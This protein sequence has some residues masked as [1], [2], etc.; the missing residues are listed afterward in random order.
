[1]R[2]LLAAAVTLLVMTNTKALSQSYGLWYDR[3]AMTWTQALPI[4]NGRLG[5]MVY[6]N[7]GVEHIQLNEETIWA[8]QPNH[9]FNPKAKA[10]LP[11]V[12]RLIFDGKYREAQELINSDIMPGYDRSNGMPYQTFGD[13]Y[14]SMPGHS[15]YTDYRRA[16]N[17]DSALSVVTYTAG[18]VTYRREAIATLGKGD[19]VVAVRF[20]AS[21]P[22]S[23][24]FNANMTSPHHDVITRSECDTATLSGVSSD[25]ERVKSLVKFQ[26]RMA[27]ET[28]G[29]HCSCAD[30]VISVSGADEAVVYVSIATNF[31]NYEDVS[32]DETA[33]AKEHM[34]KAVAKGFGRLKADHVS[35]Y[36]RYYNRV[37]INL[38]ADRYAELPTDK[39]LKQFAESTKAGLDNYF[40]ANYFQFG[41]YLLICS[42]QP[43]TQPAN[44][45]GIWNE[46]LMPKWDSKY[47]V[48]INTEM[49]Y[50][51]AEPTNLTELND[52]LFAMISDLTK[53]GHRTAQEMYGA[54]GWV[55]HH[56]T[57]LWRQTTPVDKATAGMWMMG[58]AW[59]CRHLWEH[60]LY[61]GDTEFLRRVYP[62]MLGAARFFDDTMQ[63]DPRNGCLVVCPSVSP[64]NSPKGGVPIN[65]GVTMDN[66]IL[67]ELFN[68]VADA[69]GILGEDKAVAAHYRAKIDSLP[70]MRIGSWG[71]LQEWMEDW[72]NPNDRHRHVSH[73]YALYP[74]SQ[75]SPYRTPE[76]FD[77]ARTSLTHRGDVSTGWSMGWKVCFWAR[78]LD[79]DHAMKLISDQ[80]TLSPD[81]FLV[82]GNVRQ[83]GGTYPNLFDAHPPFQID[84]NF[85]CT[86][87]I[88]EMLLQSHDGF[89]YLL[90]ALPS[91]WRDG[92]IV[93]LVARGGFEIDMEWRGGRLKRAVIRSRNGGNCRLRSLT[94]LRG[95]GLAKAKGSNPNAI[96][97]LPANQ[98]LE[99]SKEAKL[100]SPAMPKTYL[101]DLKTVKGGEYVLTF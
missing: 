22:G 18:G 14:I 51:P 57:D 32:A 46:K 41:R 53:T 96:F 38:G 6:G 99:I 8:G 3:P 93:G 21:R 16:L 60:Y 17:I 19:N 100:K 27:V 20:T 12:R 29:G 101:Y 66:E 74:G 76:L 62:T 68:E 36:R 92:N 67:F 31:V 28:K 54:D 1:M 34:R 91:T 59:M 10:A 83:R 50:W 65:T 35:E 94:P 63:T 4:G 7:P 15:K 82:V 23:I 73:L 30:G 58:A 95:K 87:G 39:R 56:N 84:G 47:T 77:A 49:N 33:R 70:P 71:Q 64:E 72:D 79:G 98:R 86:A 81:T 11:D 42:S 26:G 90:P 45:Q 48:N 24:T 40:I 69:A 13:L 2:K 88:A 61:T 25:H 9:S 89:I 44:L 75:I 5:A 52:P 55:L 78:L 43:G 97:D 80:L 37:R 85:G